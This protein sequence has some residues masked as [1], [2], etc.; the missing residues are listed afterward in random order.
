MTSKQQP[1]NERGKFKQTDTNKLIADIARGVPVAVART[2]VGIHKD[3]FYEWVNTRPEFAQ[4]LAAE[5]QRVI[6][7]ALAGLRT[8]D[9]VRTGNSKNRGVRL[10]YG[11]A[12]GGTRQGGCRDR[13]RGLRGQRRRLQ[14]CRSG[15]AVFGSRSE[16]G[17]AGVRTRNGK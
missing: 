1:Q 12:A 16:E 11:P 3:T 4:A 13:R 17:Q 6:L 9:E 5:K 15:S 8:K 2:A 7:D 10:H 14:A